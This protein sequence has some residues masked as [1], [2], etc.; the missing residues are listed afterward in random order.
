MDYPFEQS[1][2]AILDRAAEMP[3]NDE[4]MEAF[5]HALSVAQETEDQDTEYRARLFLATLSNINEDHT[6]M[7]THFSAAVGMHD[8]DPARFPGQGDNSYPDLFWLYKNALNLIISSVLFNRQQIDG[9]LDQM[10]EHFTRAGIPRIA[11]DIE[12]RDD[13]LMN[14]S[15]ERAL[16]LQELID[17]SPHD[18]PFHDCRTCQLAGKVALALVTNDFEEAQNLVYQIINYGPIGC[19]MEPETALAAFM[20]RAL[21]NGDADFARFAQETSAKA[22]PEFQSLNAVGRHL[23]FLGVTGNHSRGLG[24][25]TRYQHRLINDPL[26]THGHFQFYLGAHTLLSSTQRAGFGDLIVAGSGAVFGHDEDLSVDKLK[27]RCLE[28]ARNLAREYDARNG[29]DNFAKRFEAATAHA[30]LDIPLDIGGTNLLLKAQ[31]ATPTEPDNATEKLARFFISNGQGAYSDSQRYLLTSAEL[32]ELPE[33]DR[34][35]YALGLLDYPGKATE[36]R[37]L[38]IAELRRQDYQAA[39]FLAAQSTDELKNPDA[40]AFLTEAELLHDDLK[41]WVLLSQMALDS[42]LISVEEGAKEQAQAIARRI[43]EETRAHAD[44]ARANFQA[45]LFEFIAT[46]AL[47]PEKLD[48]ERYEDLRAQCNTVQRVGLDTV[49]GQHAVFQDTA[50]GQGILDEVLGFLISAGMRES[51]ARAAST[52]SDLYALLNYQERAVEMARLAVG[53]LHAVGLPSRTEE[54]KLGIHLSHIQPIEARELLEK[55][56]LPKFEQQQELTQLELEALLPLGATIAIHDPQ[57][58]SSV[59]INARDKAAGLGNYSLAVEAMALITDILYNQ[60]MHEQ[61]LEE[62]NQSLYLAQKLDD[63]HQAELK[64]LDSI[65][66]IQAD[67]GLTEALE[68]LGKS[69]DLAQTTGQKLYVQESLN[70]AYF[71]FERL[72]DCLAGCTEASSLAQDNDDASNAAAQLEQGAQYAFQLGSPERGAEMLEKAFEVPGIPTAQALFYANA[73]ASIY[74]DFGDSVKAQ[75]WSKKAEELDHLMD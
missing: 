25:F 47:T 68:T 2:S 31:T 44:F 36:G 38:L 72:E 57:A 8:R 30:S 51:T 39:D 26:A 54:L 50:N 24:L 45:Q 46:L 28:L 34:V 61:L 15:V 1:A 41:S 16:E 66:I 49:F 67:L 69:K 20:L 74:E 22:N 58:A 33:S 4:Q 48:V 18:D 75:Y 6:S 19:V 63:Q 14:G 71:T 32:A 37:D 70:R 3:M 59:L 52:F 13:A 53:E 17:A 60:D 65:A 42:I 10:A 9:M 7:L 5:L 56:L 40:P 21:K 11:I 23:E 35:G 62:L 12:R 43:F 29:N 55:L 73:L 64:L 27:E